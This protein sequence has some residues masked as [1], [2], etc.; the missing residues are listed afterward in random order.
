MLYRVSYVDV[1]HHGIQYDLLLHFVDLFY[2]I[3]HLRY[4]RLHIEEH[5][6]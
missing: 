4:V 1:A 3:E 6:W 5:V 2:Q